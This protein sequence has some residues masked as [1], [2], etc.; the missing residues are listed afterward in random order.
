MF[1]MIKSGIRQER[2]T[3]IFQLQEVPH[4]SHEMRSWPGNSLVARGPTI[5]SEV[6]RQY[7]KIENRRGVADDAPPTYASLFPDTS[8]SNSG[9]HFEERI[10]ATTTV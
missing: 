2:N 5:A 8:T 10:E 6:G 3:Q 9:R 7:W 1:K 4:R